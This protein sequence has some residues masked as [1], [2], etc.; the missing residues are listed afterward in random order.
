MKKR[1]A[2]LALCAFSM[3]MFGG[4]YSSARHVANV[5]PDVV[6]PDATLAAKYRLERI[7]L[8]KSIF[9]RKVA[10][11]YGQFDRRQTALN[12]KK[13]A[14]ARKAVNDVDAYME[15]LR[16]LNPAFFTPG[17][18]YWQSSRD[19]Y[20]SATAEQRKTMVDALAGS[21]FYIEQYAIDCDRKEYDSILKEDKK[22]GPNGTHAADTQNLFD[23]VRSA[24]SRD[25]P[26]VFSD[27][28][29]A[30]PIAVVVDWA[31][32][33]K[34]L[35]DYASIFSGWFWPESAEQE[36]VYHLFLVE[37]PG[38]RTDDDLW[39]EYIANI[40]K[41]PRPVECGS[42][43][44]TSEV[45]ESWLLPMGFIP[46]PGDSDFPT[47]YCFM[48]SGKDS[49]VNSPSKKI[50]SRKCFEHLVFEP[51]VDGDVLAAAIMRIANRKHRAAEAEKM[52]N[53]GVK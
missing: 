34:P 3:L 50:S 51:K 39:K 35:P 16:A 5:R 15:M 14:L 53:G 49:L 6:K 32:E 24:L 28:A 42:A 41:Y 47:T 45:W 23:S 30:T 48:R 40:G 19:S 18:K 25:Y 38:G 2:F 22:S 46:C 11:G 1:Q 37:N 20:L 12:A 33:Y 44:R 43:V 52:M 13:E 8:K 36:T 4:C 29:E 27:V 9:S 10:D 26:A 17:S 21:S 7:V 31:T